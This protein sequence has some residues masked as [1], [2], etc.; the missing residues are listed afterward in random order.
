[1]SLA[2]DPLRDDAVEVFLSVGPEE[3]TKDSA[4]LLLVA[5][6]GMADEG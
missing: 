4:R 2:V 3:L 6:E 1:V 5:G